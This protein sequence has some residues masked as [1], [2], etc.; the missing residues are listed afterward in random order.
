M[1]QKLV[2]ENKRWI[3][4]ISAPT[5]DTLS[6][7]TY[8]FY[9]GKLVEEQC[10]DLVSEEELLDEKLDFIRGNYKAVILNVFN[11]IGT[12]RLNVRFCMIVGSILGH[13]CTR[14][15]IPFYF[16]SENNLHITAALIEANYISAINDKIMIILIKEN[17]LQKLELLRNPNGYITSYE[18]TMPFTSSENAEKTCKV[19]I[20]YS[21][22]KETIVTN[23][24]STPESK[25]LMKNLQN[26]SAAKVKVVQ[27]SFLSNPA[28]V[29]FEITK[30][31]INESNNRNFVSEHLHRLLFVSRRP[32]AESPED[33]L[34]P[35]KP[36][37]KSLP[38]KQ[39][40]IVPR[41][42]NKFFGSCVVDQYGSVAL[43]RD[44]LKENCHR[45]KLIFIIDKNQNPKLKQEPIILE[46]IKNLPQKC[47]EIF[48][49]SKIAVIGFLDNLSIVC[50]WDEKI[51]SYK[52][53]DNWNG[54]DGKNLFLSF[55]NKRPEII[56]WI[57]EG[58]ESA[59]QNPPFIVYNLL[60]IM[61]MPSE[62]IKADPEWGFTVTNDENNPILLEFE[63]HIGEKK[64]ASPAFLMALLLKD[65]IKAIN[66]EMRKKPAEFAFCIFNEFDQET[67]KRVE[68][69]LQAA[70]ELKQIQCQFFDA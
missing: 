19:L 56:D 22:V 3:G 62:D 18:E 27:N 7:Q 38:A 32:N 39:E 26:Y 65:H 59:T 37:S 17:E 11:Y 48:G 44:A 6:I 4:Y 47:N 45:I 50:V 61:S 46:S 5:I 8:D 14:S 52:F 53:L 63:N 41:I 70:A 51:Q 35:K 58:D 57:P 21:N 49:D 16:I 20:N 69:H 29:L 33:M 34:L 55:E 9:T 12:F 2:V 54:L 36:F 43:W 60:Q 31:L 23:F 25:A 30:H 1:S 42:Y 66:A 64:F 10:H 28:K 13:K 68:G 40:C 24:V 67:K 15:K